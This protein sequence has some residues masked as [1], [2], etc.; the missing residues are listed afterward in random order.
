MNQKKIESS[1]FLKHWMSQN[2]GPKMRK[3]HELYFQ[4]KNEENKLMRE[5]EIAYFFKVVSGMIELQSSLCNLTLNH[6]GFDILIK[7][8]RIEWRPCD[9]TEAFIDLFEGLFDLAEVNE[10]KMIF[11]PFQS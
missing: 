9:K 4:D 7:E 3:S 2:I 11:T 1:I 6:L 8:N 10:H 5:N